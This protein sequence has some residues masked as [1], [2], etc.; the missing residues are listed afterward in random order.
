M[1]QSS[2]NY[3]SSLQIFYSSAKSQSYCILTMLTAWEIHSSW[4]YFQFLRDFS[5]VHSKNACKK[6]KHYYWLE[7]N[8]DVY[9]RPLK[10]LP[11]DINIIIPWLEIVSHSKGIPD[12][13][14]YE[15]CQCHVI[16][17][18]ADKSCS[19]SVVVIADWG[20]IGW[21]WFVSEAVTLNEC[22]MHSAFF[23]ILLRNF[24]FEPFGN[25]SG[26]LS[27]IFRPIYLWCPLLVL[28]KGK[29]FT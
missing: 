11:P 21:S 22:N 5:L 7:E 9:V 3:P 27:W 12:L 14:S 26:L 13:M 24:G 2:R 23:E 16:V 15:L 28:G 10:F 6:T 4:C 19:L 17:V 1:F 25:E 18:P 29:V 8:I 20:C